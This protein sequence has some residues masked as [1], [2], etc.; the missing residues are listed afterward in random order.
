MLSIPIRNFRKQFHFQLLITKH[1]NQPQIM[2]TLY[3]FI[4]VDRVCWLIFILV[5]K[6]VKNF[7]I[8]LYLRVLINY[9]LDVLVQ[10]FSAYGKVCIRH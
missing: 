10:V 8:E 3:Q 4:I 5:C 2:I 1:M 9:A 6:A 7:E